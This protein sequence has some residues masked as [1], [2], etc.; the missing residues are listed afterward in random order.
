MRINKNNPVKILWDWLRESEADLDED[1]FGEWAAWL[2]EEIEN[3]SPNEG[4][5]K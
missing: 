1:A 3:D 5:L 4:S 2:E